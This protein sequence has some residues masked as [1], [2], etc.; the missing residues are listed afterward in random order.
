MV[1]NPFLRIIPTEKERFHGEREKLFLE[2]VG[3]IKRSFEG[4]EIVLL[5]GDYGIGKSFFIQKF[6]EKLKK[7]GGFTIYSLVFTANLL[8]DLEPIKLRKKGSA[9]VII[10]KFDLFIFLKEEIAKKI[11]NKILKLANKG[12]LFMLAF[13]PYSLKRLFKKFPEIKKRTQTFEVPKLGYE[14][15][16]ELILS[17]LNKARRKKSKSFKPFT[18]KEVEKIWTESEGN[19]RLVLMLCSN[20]YEQKRK[21]YMKK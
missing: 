16:K 19:P 15:T 11:I 1:E 4:K 20:I 21:K 2:M 8:S 7:K 18:E 5:N 3:G 13:T 10:D 17:R 6:K 12:V 9:F 14:E